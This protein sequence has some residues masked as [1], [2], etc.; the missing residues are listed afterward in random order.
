ML[1]VLFWLFFGLGFAMIAVMIVSVFR[2]I[3]GGGKERD[4]W[5]RLT[6]KSSLLGR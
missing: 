4:A 5:K 6:G 2:D 3:R 1:D